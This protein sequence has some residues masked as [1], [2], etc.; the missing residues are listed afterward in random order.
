MSA[1]KTAIE[2]TARTIDQRA[3]N[4]RNQI[5][6]VVVLTLAPLIWAA[7]SRSIHPLAGL[8]LL[9]P[10]CGVFFLFDARL[11]NDWRYKL[12]DVWKNQQIDFA[13]FRDAV[14]A[15][16]RLPRNTLEGML[17]T[18]PDL[19]SLSSEQELAAGTR[20]ATAA[21]IEAEYGIK[22]DA[23]AVKVAGYSVAATSVIL[24]VATGSWL[25]LVLMTAIVLL[26]P[27]RSRLRTMRTK[28]ASATVRAV[29]ITQECDVDQVTNA[30]R[31]LNVSAHPSLLQALP[32]P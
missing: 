29:E 31:Y 19:G 10:A 4:F 14:S 30:T 18:L 6:T 12:L 3:K 21:I 7:V 25:T 9:F 2:Q 20:E 26:V 32:T 23:L 27:V 16:P 15:A 24:A 13:A 28:R 5:V 17:A 1:Y 22:S 11:L 8:L